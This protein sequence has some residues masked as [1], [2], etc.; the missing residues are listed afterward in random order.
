MQQNYGNQLAVRETKTSTIVWIR[1]GAVIFLLLVGAVGIYTLLNPID[2]EDTIIGLALLGIAVFICAV[3]FFVSVKIK[4]QATIFEEGVILKSGKKERRFH[5]GEIAGLRD[6]AD[7]RTY[8]IPYRGGLIGAVVASAALSIADAA[9]KKRIRSVRIVPDTYGAAEVSVVNTAGNE[10][11]EAYTAWLVKQKSVTK[12]NLTSLSLSFGD[13]LGFDSG[14]FTYKHRK[15]DT[16][17]ALSDLTNIHYD[18]SS[19]ILRF[20]ALNEK[21]KEKSLFSVG[22][23]KVINIDLLF[24]IFRLK[25]T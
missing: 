16:R 25:N 9:D 2:D 18:N 10:L 22:V 13:A 11:S 8:F 1:I 5:F 24:M 3:L 15:G 4:K 14:T 6:I 17:H 19:G 21:G 7:N 20:C 23:D 12:E